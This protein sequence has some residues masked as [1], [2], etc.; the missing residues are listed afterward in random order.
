MTSVQPT[1][2]DT[3]NSSLY[4]LVGGEDGVLN[5]VKVFYDIVETEQFAHPLL[6]LHL[7]GNGLAHSRVEQFNFLSGFL[8]GPKLYVEKHGH[9]NVR[10]MHEHVEINAESKDIWLECMSKAINQIGL[11]VA[12]KN[13]LMLNFTAAA[14]RLVNRSD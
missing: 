8:G 7:R 4:D 9:S 5:L 14:E 6:L 11:E 12:T 13:K 10:T 1:M 2:R 3:A